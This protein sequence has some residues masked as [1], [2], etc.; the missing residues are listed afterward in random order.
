MFSEFAA[1]SWSPGSIRGIAADAGRLVDREERLL[2]RQQAQ[3]QPHV[4]ERQ[5]GLQ[6]TT[7]PT[8]RPARTIGDDQQQCA[9]PSRRPT[10]RPTARTP[11]AAPVRTHRPARRRPSSGSAR[12]ADRDRED[13]QVRADDRRDPGPPQPPEI[14]LTQR[15]GVGEQSPHGCRRSARPPSHPNPVVHPVL[16]AL[17]E[18]DDVGGDQVAAPVRRHRHGFGVGEPRGDV[19]ELV[20]QRRAGCDRLR[21]VRRPRTE[22]GAARAAWT[23]S[24][25]CA[26][27]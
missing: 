18:L 16:P 26:R 3:Q 27:G 7:A 21:L 22:L 19:G 1:G 23:S 14:R 10:R 4:V 9:G 17:P 6:P 15:C 11:P 25:R 2:H 20:E 5:R 24:R 13:G 8:P 12:T